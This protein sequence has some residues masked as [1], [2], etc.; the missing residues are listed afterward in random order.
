[1]VAAKGFEPSIMKRGFAEPRAIPPS[2]PIS[3]TSM[4]LT[5]RLRALKSDA[6]RV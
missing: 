4:T 6:L 5:M 2:P 1:L 3:Y